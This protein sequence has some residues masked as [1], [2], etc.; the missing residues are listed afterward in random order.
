ME[1]DEAQPSALEN[2]IGRRH[3]PVG[4]GCRFRAEI[5]IMIAEYSVHTQ[6]GFFNHLQDC[7]LL[8]VAVVGKP[9][10]PVFKLA[11]IYT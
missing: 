10:G 5:H 2:V 1:S 7:E 6:T 8:V 4:A 9:A 11:S 3:S